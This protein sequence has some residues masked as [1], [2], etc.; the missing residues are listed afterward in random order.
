MSLP[1]PPWKFDLSVLE[2]GSVRTGRQMCMERLPRLV[3]L[4]PC[5]VLP[6]RSLRGGVAPVCTRHSH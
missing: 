4:R 2:V 3:A 6:A 5:S 1:T